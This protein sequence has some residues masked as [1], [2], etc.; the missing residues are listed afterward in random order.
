MPCLNGSCEQD[1]EYE[2]IVGCLQGII[3]NNRGC[4]FVFGGDLN[5]SKLQATANA[6]NMLSEFCSRNNIIW[7]EPLDGSVQYTFHADSMGHFS[8]IDHMLV[9]ECLVQD[10]NSVTIHVDDSNVSDHYAISCRVDTGITGGIKSNASDRKDVKL[11]W[12]KADVNLYHLVL[13]QQVSQIILPVDALLCVCDASC[14]HDLLIDKYYQDIVNCLINASKQSVP[15][16]KVGFQKFWWNEELDDLKAATIE[17]T[18]VWRC[19]GCPRSGPV[20]DNRLQ[21]KYKYKLA[22]KTAAAEAD[23]SFNDDLYY[24]LCTKDDQAF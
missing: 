1:I 19:A 5:I 16:Q 23:R 8:L 20:N 6:Y 9:S 18:S 21:C 3:D 24:K 13:Q 10:H 14:S 4:N 22:I 17:A 7:L 11:L 15:S 2:S 12:D